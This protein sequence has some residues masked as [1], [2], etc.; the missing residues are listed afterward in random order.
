MLGMAV[1]GYFEIKCISLVKK[2]GS[3]PDEFLSRR[4]SARIDRQGDHQDS[5]TPR[6]S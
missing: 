3:T 6:E 2:S 5:Y 1:G 4:V